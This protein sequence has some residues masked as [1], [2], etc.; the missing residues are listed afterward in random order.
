MEI[1]SDFIIGFPGETDADFDA[2][3][4][5]IDDIGFDSSYSFIYSK[6]PG[7]PA[8]DLPDDVPQSVKQAR[9][10]ALK[11]AVDVHVHNISFSMVGTAQ[12]VLV[13]GVSKKDEHILSGRTDNNR[14]VHF[15]ADA[16]LVGQF[17]TIKIT[18]A[19][20]YSLRGEL[21]AA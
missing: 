20:T 1:S 2:T 21:V 15:S 19:Q 17:V 8:A 7:T 4:K 16:S 12:R 6:R 3:M 14:S 10:L 13:T 11:E 18:G 9:L 5:L